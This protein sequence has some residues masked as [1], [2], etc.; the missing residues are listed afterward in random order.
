MKEMIPL[1]DTHQH[2]I[3]R[4]KAGYGWTKDIP[5]LAEGDFSLDDYNKLTRS[6]G[7]GGT[8]F[9]EAGVDD[10]DY[11]TETRFVHHLANQP[12]TPI[13]GIVA[14]IRPET[15]DD[16][17]AWLEES[18]TMGVVGYRRILHVVEDGLS[19]SDTF[20]RNVRKIG[21]AGKVFDLCFL[22]RQLPIALDL[23]KACD[24]TR[25]VIN[26]CGV[27]DIAGNAL[28]PW[29][30]NISALAKIPNTFC[31]LSGLMA[32]CAPGH[33]SLST[34]EPYISHVLE[35]FGPKRIVWGSDWPVVNLAKGIEEW[36][37]AT[38]AILEALSRDEAIAIAHKTAED[39][40]NV[41][42]THKNRENVCG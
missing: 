13:R 36:V 35:C 10:A 18:G 11:Q 15:D 25:L 5:A 14:S 42:G 7:I 34:I 9:M 22:A 32:Y 38:R 17:D 26:H 24:N 8:L 37:S 6:L 27:P 33:A 40:Y 2:L 41:K 4:D 19:R 21:Q 28:D 29:R 12:D 20:R 3:Y 23:A 31:K 30:E 16:F 1:L 39:V